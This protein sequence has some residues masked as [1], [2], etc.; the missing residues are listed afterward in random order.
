MIFEKGQLVV[1][2]ADVERGLVDKRG[3]CTAKI[4]NDGWLIRV[5]GRVK[6]TERRGKK[7]GLILIPGREN[8]LEMLVLQKKKSDAATHR[9]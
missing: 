7:T 4:I 3:R 2:G 5:A 6:I 1:S 8:T 9:Q